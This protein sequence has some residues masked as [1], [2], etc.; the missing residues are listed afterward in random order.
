MIM[1]PILIVGGTTEERLARASRLLH[2]TRDTGHGTRKKGKGKNLS[3]ITYHLSPITD[4]NLLFLDSPTAIGIDEIRQLQRKLSLKPFATGPK[5][6]IINNAQ[7]L[8]IEAQNA[9]LK[10]LEE[11]AKNSQIILTAPT[12]ESLLPTVVSRCQIITLP[13]IPQEISSRET[14][15]LISLL[16]LR[17]GKRFQKIDELNLTKDRQKAIEWVDNLTVAT[18]Q[19]LLNNLTPKSPK[20]FNN[21]TIEQLLSLLKSL[22]QTKKYLKA[23]VN[24]RLALDNLLVDL[25]QI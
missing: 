1:I 23:N 8:T 5:V 11:P 15:F 22:S 10:T 21:L 13:Q 17:I 12:A 3:P 14:D 4:P 19:A 6:A 20:R 9:F 25:P 18:R 2:G 16:H 24:L 7:N